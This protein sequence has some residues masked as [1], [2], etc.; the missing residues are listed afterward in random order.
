MSSLW[1]R[2]ILWRVVLICNRLP[3]LVFVTKTRTFVPHCR[4]CGLIMNLIVHKSNDD[5]LLM[6]QVDSLL[7]PTLNT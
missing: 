6:P 2:L 5:T 7:L 4:H 3:A 1:Q